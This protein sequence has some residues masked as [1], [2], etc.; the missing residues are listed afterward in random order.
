MPRAT[1]IEH[2]GGNLFEIISQAL[3]QPV[4]KNRRSE[5]F[6]VKSQANS[7]G[8][9]VVGSGLMYDDLGFVGAG[10]IE[11]IIVSTEARNAAQNGAYH[12]AGQLHRP[13]ITAARFGRYLR[14]AAALDAEAVKHLLLCN[15]DYDI[16]RCP[17]PSEF[18]SYVA[19]LTTQR[20]FT[21]YLGDVL[22]EIDE[23]SPPGL[24]TLSDIEYRHCTHDLIPSPIALRKRNATIA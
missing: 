5:T 21:N 22:F 20:R 9:L 16:L 12:I 1:V 24:V 15:F 11:N 6:Q 13:M 8:L 14:E 4:I 18:E 19:H 17:L 2:G 23:F 7:A 3:V 10:E